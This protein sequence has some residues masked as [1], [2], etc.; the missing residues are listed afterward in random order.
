M[1]LAR[2]A[3]VTLVLGALVVAAAP[4]SAGGP[5]SV[6]LVSPSTGLSASLYTTDEAYTTLMTQLDAEP[7]AAPDRGVAPP[8]VGGDQIVVTWMVHDVQP[9]RVD[10]I[11]F[12][13]DG[14]PEWV[15]TTQAMGAG[16]IEFD[17]AGLWHRPDDPEALADLMA[18]L[19][20]IGRTGLRPAVADPDEVAAA[21]DPEA[22]AAAGE[23][24]PPPG[25]SAIDA[26]TWALPA[27]AGGIVVGVLGDRWLRRRREGGEGGRWQLVDV[28]GP[29]A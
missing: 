5:T 8:H 12:D 18:D 28:P 23:A 22:A 2:P 10:R 13:G 27:V 14:L 29:S 26:A 21:G 24:A 7:V 25:D 16:P 17:D 15:H 3:A 11:T 20:L 4:A 1:R 19:G 6:L 9:W